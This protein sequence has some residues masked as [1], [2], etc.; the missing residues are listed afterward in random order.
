M[1]VIRTNDRT[2]GRPNDRTTD[3]SEYTSANAH[4]D[5]HAIPA[6]GDC[7]DR[8][9]NHDRNDRRTRLPS[10]ACGHRH[11]LSTGRHVVL[12]VAGRDADEPGRAR[13][14]SELERLDATGPGR[15]GRLGESRTAPA[16]A[17]AAGRGRRAA[18][19]GLRARAE[20]RAHRAAA[21]ADGE[22]EGEPRRI[23][24]ALA[25]RDRARRDRSRKR[26]TRWRWSSNASAARR[27]RRRRSACWNRSPRGP[28]TSP[29]SSSSRV[30]RRNAAT[31]P[32]SRK[33]LDALERNAS[34]VA[35]RCAASG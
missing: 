4:L 28:A 19:K 14:H 13:A 15:S 21:G 17:A 26:R 1:Q 31:A 12:R 22:P 20:E 25:A 30:S 6:P 34:V 7:R 3:R 9:R 29:R 35:A 11:D 23:G 18:G 8:Q 16:A 5:E 33:A 10:K 24:P 27:T 2:T 32:R